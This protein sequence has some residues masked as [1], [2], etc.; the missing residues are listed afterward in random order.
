MK[1]ENKEGAE[2]Y[3]CE[4]I[5]YSQES[6]DKIDN[7]TDQLKFIHIPELKGL[8]SAR[9]AQALSRGIDLEIDIPEPVSNIPLNKIDLCRLV[10]IIVD[11][12]VDELSTN[13]YKNEIK[14]LKF[15]IL[16]DNK[17]VLIICSNNCKNTPDIKNIF[18]KEYTTKGLGRGLGLYNLKKICEKSENILV[19]THIKENEFSIIITI[20]EEPLC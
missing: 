12:A 18:S 8:L 6:L 13:A 10:G 15:G 3:L 20:R 2:K 5:D 7:C 9:L 19:A 4:T 17:D 11:N 14:L 1:G 16:I